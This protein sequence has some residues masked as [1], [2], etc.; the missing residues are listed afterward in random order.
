MYIIGILNF[1]FDDTDPGEFHH[2]VQLLNNRTYNV[3]YDKL[4][5]IYLEMPK[6]NKTEDQ[7]ENL[8]E[9]WLFV[10]RNL[11]R[12]LERPKA[13]QER[14]FAKLFKAAEIAK[15]TKEE[16][17]AYEESLKVYRDWKNTI[18]TA[19]QKAVKKATQKARKEG[20]KEGLKEG[21]AEGLKEGLEEGL[22]KGR[23]ETTYS[24]ARQMKSEGLPAVTIAK[25]TGLTED[26]IIR[27]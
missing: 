6:F 10:L 27:L 3:F 24:I 9:K 2:E 4:T 25:I 26:E 18:D 21:R 20:L 12:L 14:V 5:F 7:L 11:S 8:F 13:L 19:V 15:F 17:D 1:C 16:Y 23:K 22:E